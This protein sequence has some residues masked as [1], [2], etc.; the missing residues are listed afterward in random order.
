MT[1]I[2][3]RPESIAAQCAPVLERVAE[4]VV[5]FDADMNYTYLNSHAAALLGRGV[6]D[7]LGKNYWTEYPEARGT[8]FA[9]AYV[10][11]LRTQRASTLE[12]YYAPFDRWFENRI[13]P[14]EDG[15]SIF[16]TDI[17]ERKRADFLLSD[18][19]TIMEMIAKGAPLAAVLEEITVRI[20]KQR[21]DMLSTILLVDPDGVHMRHGA[22]PSMSATFLEAIDGQPM[23]PSAGSCGTA[24]YRGEAVFVTDIAIDPLWDDYREVALAEGL[25]ASWSTP[26]VSTYGKV[27]G[28]FAMYYREPRS[29]GD[30]D[31]RLI[32]MAT[33]LAGIAIERHQREESLREA[34]ERLELAVRSADIGLWDWDVHSDQV[35]Y[36]PEW[37]SMLGY[38]NGEIS[39][40]FSAWEDRLHPEDRL[41]AVGVVERAL[42]EHCP[43]YRNEFRMRHRDGSYLWILAQGSLFEDE[44]GQPVRLIGSHIDITERKQAEEDL[45]HYAADIEVAYDATIDGWSRALDLRDHETE[46]HSER[47]TELTLQLARS[48]GMNDEQLVSVRRGALLH[49]IGKMGVPDSILF[50]SG[51]LTSEEWLLMRQHPAL[52]YALLSPIG[53]LASA[54]DIPYC[55]H[56]W[57]DGTGYPR[58]LRGDEIPL[59]ARLF[60]VID[61]W[62]ALR[63]DRPYRKALLEEE[64]LGYIAS[65]AGTHFDPEV[66]EHFLN[67]QG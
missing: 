6:N 50:K 23:G 17:T 18:E 52:A 53:Y 19:R 4:G 29:P 58:G 33:H 63:S 2:G 43:T 46:G 3:D 64:A 45:R 7:L 10:E 22:A 55:H 11:A 67:A 65:L 32:G 35:I 13:Y 38:A 26:I 40:T 24:A 51:E 27:L 66:V 36:S 56:E 25:R 5:A 15:I 61:V 54:V 31:I 59:A 48:C 28:T 44:S 21:R 62:D 39:N 49:D 34:Q 37:K 16:F 30:Y 60:A 8:V 57:W 47:V 12:D 14:S 42:E 41:K 9:N 20:E 1:S